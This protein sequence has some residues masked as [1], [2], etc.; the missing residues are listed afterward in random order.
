VLGD[1]VVGQVIQGNDEET[2]RGFGM[3]VQVS[4]TNGEE[5]ESDSGRMASHC[6]RPT[7]EARGILQPNS[8]TSKEE[9]TQL[10]K[11]NGERSGIPDPR[12]RFSSRIR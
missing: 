7:D 5:S 12:N 9:G 11:E 3:G 2:K 8:T 10:C 1:D 4:R 6:K